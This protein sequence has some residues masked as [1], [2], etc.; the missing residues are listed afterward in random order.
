MPG[1]TRTRQYRR[2]LIVHEYGTGGPIKFTI[3]RLVINSETA[4]VHVRHGFVDVRSEWPTT[5]DKSIPRDRIIETSFVDP[6][7][8]IDTLLA[9][10]RLDEE[11]PY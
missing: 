4:S 2:V 3:G 10:Y 9:K 5:D 8:G 6:H 7:C 1:A 11:P